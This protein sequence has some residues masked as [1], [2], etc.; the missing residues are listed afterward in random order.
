MKFGS[1]NDLI[2]KVTLNFSLTAYNMKLQLSQPG[3]VG[4]VA[5]RL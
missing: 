1:Y 4:L 2:Y 5:F 3:A